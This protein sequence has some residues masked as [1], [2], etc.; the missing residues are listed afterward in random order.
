MLKGALKYRRVFGSLPMVDE[1]YKYCPLEEEWDRAG[2]ICR[3][4]MPFYDMTTL[5]SAISYPTS[6]LY[7]LQVWKIQSLLMENVKD[8]NDVIKNMAE[9]MMVKFQKYWD[10]YSVV[11]AFGAILDPRMKLQ[12][13]AYCFEKI[14]PL[15]S[16]LK[17]AKIKD[18]L[19]NL[20]A[21]Y[22]KSLPTTTS[23]NVLKCKQGQSSSSSSASL[24]HLS[25]FD[26]SLI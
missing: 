6:N 17:L 10:E 26:V 22:S 14:D 5:I 11:L 15:T 21:E 1:S 8:G 20:F 9:L 13:L 25:L 2:K 19:Y 4:L 16:E 3:F 23:T 7:F 12:A 24:P 18:K